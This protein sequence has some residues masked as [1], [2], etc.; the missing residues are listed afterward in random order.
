MYISYIPHSISMCFYS[1]PVNLPSNPNVDRHRS[2]WAAQ[3]SKELSAATW[4]I[5][6]ND[7]MGVSIHGGTM[8]VPWS[9]PKLCFAREKRPWGTGHSLAPLF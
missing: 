4:I 8:G 5:G 6:I 1:I 7:N 3:A 9:A 2:P